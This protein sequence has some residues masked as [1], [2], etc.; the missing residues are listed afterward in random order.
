MT[1]DLSYPLAEL[2]GETVWAADL[3]TN[4]ERPTGLT[5]IG[6]RGA[7]SLRAGERRRAHFAHRSGATC[8]AGETAL[9]ALAIRALADG[10]VRQSLRGDPYPMAIMCDDCDA[11]RMADLA[12]E[13]GLSV[14]VNRA[15]SPEARPDLL[16]RSSSGE[17]LFVIEVIV[18]HAPADS[19][20]SRTPVPIDSVQRFRTFRTP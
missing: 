18:T 2:D 19:E 7:M 17:P 15:V 20:G 3:A 5:C 10:L 6:C 12:R 13:P 1:A 16:V 11:G 4:A 14:D 8:V 9:H